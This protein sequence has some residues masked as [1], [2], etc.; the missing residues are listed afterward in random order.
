MD[1][2]IS[3]LVRPE[4][5]AVSVFQGVTRDNF[6]G[7]NVIHLSYECYD[8]M[9]IAQMQKIAEEAVEKFEIG[10]VYI[11]HRLGVVPVTEVSIS[12]VCV[13]AHRKAALNATEWL[14]DTLKEKVPI[15]K[16]EF[17]SDQDCEA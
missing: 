9:A 17:Y 7:K 8:K 14:I 13:S 12:I 3:T 1:Q 5:G 15:W 4:F 2:V 6:N 11:G 10:G 16:K